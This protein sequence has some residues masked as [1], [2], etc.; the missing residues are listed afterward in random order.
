ML[1][2]SLAERPQHSIAARK[3][4]E[5]PPGLAQFDQLPGKA[6]VGS[7]VVRGLYGGITPVTL[8]RWVKAGRVPAP[9]K[10]AGSR[11]NSWVVE[12]LRADLAA[13]EVDHAAA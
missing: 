8:W 1:S 13:E 5:I 12:E 2:T 9:R 3:A 11:I 4:T 7:G 10:L 6:R